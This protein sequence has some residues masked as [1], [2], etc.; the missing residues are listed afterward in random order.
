MARLKRVSISQELLQEM[1][2]KGWRAGGPDQCVECTKGL[3]EDAE[4]VGSNYD[5][6]RLIAYMLF[7]HGS[8]EDIQLG[9]VIPELLVEHTSY[10]YVE[11]D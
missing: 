7:E 4:V 1:L 5:H 11:G 2:T 10:V 8:F 9:D 3:P 6:D